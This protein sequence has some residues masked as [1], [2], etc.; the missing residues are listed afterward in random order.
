MHTDVG[1][2]RNANSF[3]YNGV[4]IRDLFGERQRHKK[5]FYILMGRLD[6]CGGAATCKG[7]LSCNSID[8]G[9][10]VGF[11]DPNFMSVNILTV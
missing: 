5:Y 11:F 2:F 7:Q 10:L 8:S 1:P 4:E 6:L 9:L 3:R